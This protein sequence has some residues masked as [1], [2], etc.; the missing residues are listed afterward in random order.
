MERYN[1]RQISEVQKQRT[2][3]HK[4]DR[5]PPFINHKPWP[6]CFLRNPLGCKCEKAPILQISIDLSEKTQNAKMLLTSQEAVIRKGCDCKNKQSRWISDVNLFLC[7]S[8]PFF[9]FYGNR[10]QQI[11]RGYK[12][13]T[14]I[15]QLFFNPTDAVPREVHAPHG[16]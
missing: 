15:G 16:N 8:T 6:V 3:K 4:T 10:F 5:N 9:Y 12:S 11:L 13:F 2:Q 14:I 7:F 1:T